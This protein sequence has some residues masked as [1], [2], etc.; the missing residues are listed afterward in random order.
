MMLLKSVLR[1]LVVMSAKN[2]LIQEL[3][4]TRLSAENANGV[5]PVTQELHE[6]ED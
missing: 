1:L 4:N 5:C 6:G 2:L 3:T